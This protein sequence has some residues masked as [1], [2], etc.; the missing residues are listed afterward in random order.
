MN[1]RLLAVIAVALGA[2]GDD[3]GSPP[4]AADAPSAVDAPAPIDGGA[5]DAPP[6]D[7]GGAACTGAAYD[8]CTGNGDCMSGNCRVFQG[9][10]LQVCTQTCDGSNPCPTQ[11][12][13]AVHCNGMGICRPQTANACTPS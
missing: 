4:P 8:P 13:Q 5:V 12:G 3:G 2:C 6:I 11:N 9:A 10:G 7:G 1:T